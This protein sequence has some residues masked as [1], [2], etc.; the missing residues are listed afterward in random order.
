MVCE[1][2]YSLKKK[3]FLGCFIVLI[4][5][6]LFGVT[7]GGRQEDDEKGL[8]GQ[9][10]GLLS[11]DSRVRDSSVDSILQDRLGI[12]QQLIP[13][14]DPANAQKYSDETR[15]VAAYLLGKFR[16]SEAVPVLSRAL[17]DEPGVE[18]IFNRSRYYDVPFWTAL[19]RIGRPAVPAMIENIETSDNAVLRKRSL[20]VLYHVLGGKRRITELLT[21][22]K[23]RT[24]DR[25][26]LQRI[27]AAVQHTQ[28][29]F[30]EDK[31]PLY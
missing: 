27:E 30:K 3:W 21:K 10:E 1:Q 9:I 18:L 20:S 15:S 11:K 19:V 28:E 24:K 26:K 6:A 23:V 22:L 2:N 17:A 8:P 29:H 25:A 12:V 14:I 5:V 31:E 7:T 13:L 4:S 16:A